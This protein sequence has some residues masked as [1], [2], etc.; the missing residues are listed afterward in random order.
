MSAMELFDSYIRN[1]ST[2][3]PEPSTDSRQ[4]ALKISLALIACALLG[5]SGAFAAMYCSGC[6]KFSRD[7]PHKVCAA[8][9]PHPKPLQEMSALIKNS[10]Q[11][12]RF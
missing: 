6:L 3:T 5:V 7:G 4:L 12:H 10:S 2:P 1:A 11:S 8:H 9:D